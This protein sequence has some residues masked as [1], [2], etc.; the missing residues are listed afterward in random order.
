MVFR[1]GLSRGDATRKCGYAIA[2]LTALIGG[3]FNSSGDLFLVF[4]VA[5]STHI[6]E[7]RVQQPL[8]N[9]N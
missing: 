8:V 3:I 6:N 1:Q 5:S 7:I 2:L 9:P 4:G